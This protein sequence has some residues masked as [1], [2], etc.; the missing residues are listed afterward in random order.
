MPNALEVRRTPP[1]GAARWTTAV[2]LG[3]VVTAV[4]LLT[5]CDSTSIDGLNVRAGP[6]TATP[7]VASLDESGTAVT[8]ACHTR[9]EPVHGDPVWHRITQPYDGYVTNYYV[10]TTGDVLER[11]P[12]C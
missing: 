9:G 10:R 12:S 6:S 1:V 7:V 3:G 2:R 5:A 8:I 11:K 4:A